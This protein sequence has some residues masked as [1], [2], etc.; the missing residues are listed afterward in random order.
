MSVMK[1]VEQRTSARCLGVLEGFSG[2]VRSRGGEIDCDVV[3]ALFSSEEAVSVALVWNPGAHLFIKRNH[4][5]QTVPRLRLLASGDLAE[6]PLFRHS[7]KQQRIIFFAAEISR[8]L[9]HRRRLGACPRQTVGLPQKEGRVSC[10]FAS[11]SFGMRALTDSHAA[12][13]VF[14]GFFIF[15]E[16]GVSKA[17]VGQI[18]GHDPW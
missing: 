2:A 12:L 16:P 7:L 17:S 6:K 13:D 4:A 11:Q 10:H 1:G 15:S 14:N 8:L 9:D 5:P 18:T 3:N